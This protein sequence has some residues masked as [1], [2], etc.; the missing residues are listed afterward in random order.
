MK[1]GSGDLE[2]RPEAGKGIVQLTHPGSAADLRHRALR[3]AEARGLELPEQRDFSLAE[4]YCA[5]VKAAGFGQ[6]P[7]IGFA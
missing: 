5:P 1:S 7:S 6:Q 3:L 2:K 4:L